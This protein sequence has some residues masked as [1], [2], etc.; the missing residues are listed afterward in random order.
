VTLRLDHIAGAAFI[1]FGL[2]VFALSGDLPTGQLSMPGSGFLPKIVAGFMILF[3]ALL[4]LR[5][6]EGPLFSSIVWDDGK[7]ALLVTAITAAAISLYTVLGFIVTM[8]AMMIALLIVIERRT[9]LRAAAYSVAVA[10]ITF[11]VFSYLLK[12]PLPAF[13]LG[14]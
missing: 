14:L 7:H 6:K 12:T 13:Q 8:V 5:A 2:L 10:L 9:P 4:V 3:G 11:I 1:G